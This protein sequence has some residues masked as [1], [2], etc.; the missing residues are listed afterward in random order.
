MESPPW[1]KLEAPA[2]DCLFNRADCSI[3]LCHGS[4]RRHLPFIRRYQCAGELWNSYCV[5]IDF[6]IAIH[7]QILRIASDPNR[8]SV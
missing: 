5:I 8:I 6:T 1:K 2:L 7:S 3:A 4:E